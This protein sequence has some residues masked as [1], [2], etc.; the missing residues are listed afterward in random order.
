MTS[1]WS[2]PVVGEGRFARGP[3]G[4]SDQLPQGRMLGHEG[5]L[6]VVAKPLGRNR[7]SRWLHILIPVPTLVGCPAGADDPGEAGAA[8]PFQR[9]CLAT[10]PARPYRVHRSPGAERTNAA[11]FF[12]PAWARLWT[13]LRRLAKKEPSWCNEGS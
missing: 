4:P 1:T 5:V 2:T 7:R 8:G 13:I 10:R 11:C 9:G 6:E 12:H 3:R